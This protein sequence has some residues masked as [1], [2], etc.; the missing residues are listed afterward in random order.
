M[1]ILAIETSCDETALAV[2]NAR[3]GSLVLEKDQVYSQIPLHRPYG[4]VVP[5]LAARKHAETIIPLLESVLGRTKL[6]SLDYIAVTA[7]PG[8][9]TSLLLGVSA[10]KTLAYATSLPLVPIN[11]INGHV[12]SNWLSNKELVKNSARYFPAM[13][14]VVSGGHTELVLMRGHGRYKLIGQTLDD[15]VG[16]CFDKVAKLLGLGYPGGPLISKLA[17]RGDDR[18]F[19]LPRPMFT[20]NNFD[21]SFAGL[22]TA[23]LYSL[24]K[25]AIW[26]KKEVADYAASF[27]RAA[28]DVLVAK[29]VKAAQK[30]Q[31]RAVM[32]AGGVAA[33]KLLVHDLRLAC[34]KNNWP[35]FHPDLKYTGDNA[36][37]IATAAYY[38]IKNKRTRIYRGVKVLNIKPRSN[39]QLA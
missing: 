2:L 20:S 6:K 13:V 17:E 5:E 28:V 26:H 36:A 7:G 27:Q 16:E 10:A 11:H 22:K 34:Q 9:I 33:N 21:F 3:A 1:K 15:A 23:V 39:W 19:A 18:I 38:E 4:G 25:K 12:Y 35:F 29:T 32:V 14:L 24:Q 37:M 8:L 30:Y 31:V